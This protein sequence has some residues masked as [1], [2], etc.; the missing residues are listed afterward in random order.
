MDF[1]GIRIIDMGEW[2]YILYMC[3]CDL[4]MFTILFHKDVFSPSTPFSC[5]GKPIFEWLNFG[6]NQLFQVRKFWHR[7]QLRFF[8]VTLKLIPKTK[9]IE[10]SAV[11][12]SNNNFGSFTLQFTLSALASSLIWT[13][14]SFITLCIPLSS[15][16][17]ALSSSNFVM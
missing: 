7:G 8:Y 16:S 3:V 4:T 1:A 14:I 12:L 2:H 17:I 5:K 9:R 15:C 6:R 11:K 10:V 13:C